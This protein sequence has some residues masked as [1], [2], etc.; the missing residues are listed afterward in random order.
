MDVRMNNS[1][2]NVP[3]YRGKKMR[4]FPTG[5]R[6]A[7]IAETA[8]ILPL[9]FLIV[10]G[11]FWVG[12]AYRIYG[13]ITH[14]AREGARAAATPPCATCSSTNDPS[15]NAWTAVQNAM[16]AASLDPHILQQP[17]ILPP[18]C[19]CSTTATTAQCAPSPVACDAGET[20]IC[21]QGVSRV[22]G[23]PPTESNVQL[24]AP[25]NG[26]AGECGIS[27]SFQ[28]PFTFPF[29]PLTSQVLNIRAQA[30]MRAET[31]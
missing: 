16:N 20:N 3:G 27:V 21:V 11:I 9:L 19:Q 25:A 26:A 7:E 24:S 17:T 2:S 6:G 28:Y 30:Q 18:V 12:Q 4:G 10:L 23:D 1:L 29:N 5:T 15:A 22:T 13:A 8:I 31:Q 14:A